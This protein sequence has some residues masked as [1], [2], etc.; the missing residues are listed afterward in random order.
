[1]LSV[2]EME[3]KTSGAYSYGRYRSWKQC[4]RVLRKM[5][6]DDR[7]VEAILLSKWTRWAA[8]QSSAPYGKATSED[9]RRY[10][11]RCESKASVEELVRETFCDAPLDL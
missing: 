11:E 8:D 6:F 2:E 1:M 3:E 4:I 5:G 7:E 9:L 10:I